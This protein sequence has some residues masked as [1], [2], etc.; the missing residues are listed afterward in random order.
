MTPT[1]VLDRAG[2]VKLVAGASGG[3]KIINGTMQVI[4]N[5]LGNDMDA[6]AAVAAPRFHH[7]WLPDVLNFERKWLEELKST[8]AG[9]AL[10]HDLEQR[11]HTIE[12]SGSIGIVQLIRRARTGTGWDAASDPRKGGKPA[13]F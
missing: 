5:V 13:G 1:I 12:P 6:E 10:L 2:R 8:E 7:Q 9:R 3:P 4:R 11:A